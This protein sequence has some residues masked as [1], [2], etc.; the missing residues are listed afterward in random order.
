M[1]ADGTLDEF[2]GQTD[3]QTQIAPVPRVSIQAFCEVAATADAIT[4]SMN[5]RRMLKA[6]VK[7]HMGGAPAAIEAYR[8][9][10]TPNVIVIECN[11]GR[12]ALLGYL[13][14]LADYCDAGTRVV[15]IGRSNDIGLYRELMGRGVSEYI[16]SPFEVLSFVRTIS[17]LY[18][19]AGSAPVGRLLAVTGVKGG[20]GASSIAHNVAWAISREFDSS[21]VLVDM[22]LGFGTAGL[23][24][25][26][27]PPQGVA[28]IVF[29]PERLDANFV[30]R[31]LSKCTENLSLL[32]APAT[33]ERN[34]DLSE[35]AFDG[36]IDIL[37]ST[38]PNIVLDVPHVWTAWSRRILV[39]A[40]EIL[41][42]AAPDLASLR[43]TKSLLDTLR[44]ARPND[45]PP[46]L[47]MNFVGVPKRPEISVADFAKAVDLEPLSSI[48]FDPKLFGTAA[49]NGQMIAEIDTSH[50]VTAAIEEIARIL[51]GRAEIKQTKKRFSNPLS[52]LLAR[53][54]S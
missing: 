26:Q 24:F 41:V 28:E 39:S 10:P 17:E 48:P 54:R 5:D 23:D 22:D 30:D 49:N 44:A 29:A 42:V 50:T 34:Y 1:E 12:N 52:A 35:N 13:D 19:A 51:T 14:E 38:I 47:V 45:A 25:N 20:V 53:R 36:L 6:H 31:L 8:S 3:G 15:V 7:V 18:A 9:A 46:R 16:V 43:N 4:S 11:Q 32:A 37:R 33:L 27:D 2:N 21:T 40:D